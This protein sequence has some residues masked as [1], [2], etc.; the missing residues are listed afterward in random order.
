MSLS[1]SWKT[2]RT[3]AVSLVAAGTIMAVG[4]A[5]IEAPAASPTLDPCTSINPQVLDAYSRQISAALKWASEDASKN[6]KTGT[7]AVAATNSRD[8]LQRALN[9]SNKASKDLSKSNP[10]V[11]T[12]AE[13]GQTSAHVRY[14]LETVPQAAHWSMISKIYHTSPEARRAFEGSVVVLEQG[15]QLFAEAGRCYMDAY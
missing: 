13:A 1:R 3:R 12:Y 11:T 8:L 9:R 10:S 2:A 15:Y 6:G 5:A 7:Y 14:I 4:L